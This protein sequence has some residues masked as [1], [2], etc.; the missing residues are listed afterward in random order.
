[1]PTLTDN[2]GRLE[3]VDLR[4]VWEKE[5][6]DFTP[7]LGRPENIALLGDAIGL[8]LEVEAQEKDVG[9]F[10][11]DILCKD[12]GSSNWVLVENQLERTDHTHLGQLLTYA[13]GLQAVTIVW[14]AHRFTEEHRATLDWLNEITDD[15]FNFFGLEIE[16][17]RIGTSPIA[18]K[19]N[20]VCMPN[21][22]SKAVAT[23][24]AK[25][26]S[27]SL[28]EAKQLQ[29][30]FW[31]AFRSYLHDQGS[32]IMSSKPLPQNW[33]NLALGR[34]G[35]R[36]CA[37][38]SLWDSVAETFDSNEVRA[39]VCVETPQSKAHFA[40]LE[41]QKAPIEAELGEALTWHNPPEK[42]AC[43]V[44][45]RKP[46]ALTDRARWP[47]YHAWLLQKLT[48]LHRVFGPRVR[49]LDADPS[50]DGAAVGTMAAP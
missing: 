17:W 8:E 20:V 22:W 33:M 2:L 7:W 42:K 36:L 15:R 10:R 21:D 23:G 24:A 11:A 37:V 3:R 1:M 27:E 25:V 28:S 14:I 40:C 30:D 49:Q 12:T 43:R 34:S 46:V 48:A 26:A 39:E 44:Y 50:Q 31:I 35:F 16:L 41:S 29:L 19:F 45:L 5:A 32:P 18:P 47:E 6:E 38:A 4:V 13:A 9:P